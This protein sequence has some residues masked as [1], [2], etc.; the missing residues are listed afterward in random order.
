MRLLLMRGTSM[1]RP[2]HLFVDLLRSSVWSV[3]LGGL[4]FRR[5]TSTWVYLYNAIHY[6]F[7]KMRCQNVNNLQNQIKCHNTGWAKK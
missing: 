2:R 7:H 1:I 5:P 6:S 4:R 3:V